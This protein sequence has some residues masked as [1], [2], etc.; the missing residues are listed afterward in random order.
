MSLLF[1]INFHFYPFTLD[2]SDLICLTG[3]TDLSI[4]DET[5]WG[6]SS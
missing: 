3:E 1:P 5:L 2:A 6:L 4:A